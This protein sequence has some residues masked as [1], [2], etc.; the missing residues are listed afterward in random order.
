MHTPATGS[1]VSSVAYGKHIVAN[2]RISAMPTARPS[3]APRNFA[4]RYI[5]THRSGINSPVVKIVVKYVVSAQY[6]GSCEASRG[7]SVSLKN[8]QGI[9]AVNDV[10]GALTE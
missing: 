3:E 5:T 10:P 8:T 4:K 2:A 1:P 9:S 6:H 7:I